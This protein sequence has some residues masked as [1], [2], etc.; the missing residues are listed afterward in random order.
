MSFA[1]AQ[2]GPPG[3]RRLTAFPAGL[4]WA[5]AG[6]SHRQTADQPPVF[7]AARKSH[8]L[9]SVPSLTSGEKYGEM[10]TQAGIP[11]HGSRWYPRALVLVR[12]QRLFICDGPV[13]PAAF[14]SNKPW[15]DIRGLQ[16]VRNGPGVGRIISRQAKSQTIIPFHLFNR[17][18]KAYWVIKL[19]DLYRQGLSPE[20]GSGWTRIR[21][22]MFRLTAACRANGISCFKLVANPTQDRHM[23]PS[24]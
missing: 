6:K 20:P 21:R 5:N 8:R 16:M 9:V 15:R 14:S 12:H 22:K 7:R 13:G 19:M 24:V 17:T 1:G 10:D 3:E 2:R 23:S 4:I 11:A 18:T